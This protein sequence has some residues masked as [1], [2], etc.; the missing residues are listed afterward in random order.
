MYSGMF[1]QPPL[2]PM[3]FK[4]LFVTLEI[5]T[6]W[7]IASHTESKNVYHVCVLR[8]NLIYY[9]WSMIFVEIE[10]NGFKV[11][12]ENLPHLP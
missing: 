12:D 10:P 9:S 3:I 4:N 6:T 5:M 8:F 1:R 7:E 2:L 11:P